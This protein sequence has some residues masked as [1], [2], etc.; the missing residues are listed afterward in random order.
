MD[1]LLITTGGT[2][3]AQPYPDPLSPPLMCNPLH[4]DKSIVPD[5]IKKLFPL[6]LDSRFVCNLDSKQVE[7]NHLDSVTDIITGH[8]HKNIIITCGTDRMPEIARRIDSAIGKELRKQN[9]HVILTGAMIPL[10]NG[11]YSDGWNNLKTAIENI[12]TYPAGVGLV[13]PTLKKGTSNIR[14][15]FLK[16][17]EAAK[18]FGYYEKGM[19]FKGIFYSTL[20]P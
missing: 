15:S 3:D 10:S 18:D 16:A 1:I 13:V 19:P 9:R 7:N 11:P 6:H 14:I 20:S 4:K 5:A 12:E 8:P 17:A 2:I